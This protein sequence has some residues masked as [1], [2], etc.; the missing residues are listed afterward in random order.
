MDLSVISDNLRYLLIGAWPDG[1][2]GGAAL[3]VLLSVASA[4]ASALLGLC[5]GIA[6]ALLGPRLRLVLRTVLGLLRAVPVLMLIF[7]IYFLLPMVFGVDIPG[8]LTVVVALSLVGGAYLSHA[9]AAGIAAVPRGQWQAGQALG[10]G[11]LQTLRL[12]ILPQALPTMAPSFLNQWIALIKDTSLA[13][14][15]GVAELSF[16]STQV[17]NRL[18]VHP[19]EIFLFATL[20]YL[21]LCTGLQQLVNRLAARADAHLRATA[22]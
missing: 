14:V 7:W 13:Y 6:L 20:V 1:P 22:P 9:V 16:V 2:L 3:T 11:R 18:L 21:L 4:L 8:V 5:G 12:I 10:L 15:I 17:S 19:A